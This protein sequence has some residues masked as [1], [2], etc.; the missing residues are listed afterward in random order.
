M[1]G[2]LE[3][4]IPEVKMGSHEFL[5]QRFDQ[6]SPRARQDLM[7]S[8]L[9]RDPLQVRISALRTYRALKD[10]DKKLLQIDLKDCKKDPE[11]EV[12]EECP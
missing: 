6:L 5:F 2:R 10:A 7:R 8:A 3:S 9:K 11:P 12:R 4:S 1:E